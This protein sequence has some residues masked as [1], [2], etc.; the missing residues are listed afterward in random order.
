MPYK[1]VHSY[2]DIPPPPGCNIHA[3]GDPEIGYYQPTLP[4]HPWYG[5]ANTKTG[6]Y[7]HPYP[8][9][10]HHPPTVPSKR[11]EGRIVCYLAGVILA[12]LALVAVIVVLTMMVAGQEM[13]KG[14][15]DL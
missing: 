1:T 12:I 10:H 9:G 2:G 7:P 6:F 8:T 5:T 3:Y 4:Q 11:K 15:R 13:V 14:A